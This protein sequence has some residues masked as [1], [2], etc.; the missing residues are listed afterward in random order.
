MNATWQIQDYYRLPCLWKV[1]NSPGLRKQLRVWSGFV[2]D[3]AGHLKATPYRGE[4]LR[5]FR[6]DRLISSQSLSEKA[7]C[8]LVRLLLS[9]AKDHVQDWY[10]TAPL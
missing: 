4:S 1:D 8:F 6:Y 9:T 7:V 2:T 5:I 3:D 10:Y